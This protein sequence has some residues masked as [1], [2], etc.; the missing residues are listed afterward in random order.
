MTEAQ[1]WVVIALWPILTVW[2]TLAW[3][4]A[5]KGEDRREKTGKGP[6]SMK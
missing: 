2:T 4:A 3:V 6:W 5:S 1:I